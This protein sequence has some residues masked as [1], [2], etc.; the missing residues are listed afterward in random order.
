VPEASL[1]ALEQSLAKLEEYD[2]RGKGFD[3][4]MKA[5]RA[6]SIGLL[7]SADKLERAMT[8]PGVNMPAEARAELLERMKKAHGLSEERDYIEATFSQL[9]AVRKETLPYRLRADGLVS[10]RVSEAA[11]RKMTV[12]CALLAGLAGRTAREAECVAHLRLALMA[13]A[14]EQYRAAHQQYP[15]SLSELATAHPDPFDGRP[16]RYRK[17][18]FGYLIYSIGPDLHDNS[19]ARRNG[20]TGDLVFTVISGPKAGK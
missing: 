20:K 4:A 10:E 11:G 7:G 19:G 18:G 13:L 14:L 9:A 2:A 5:E 15:G 6:T 12:V 1:I 3:L 17:N 16:M 8:A